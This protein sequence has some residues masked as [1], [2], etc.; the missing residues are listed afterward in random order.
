MTRPYSIDL[1]ERAV[2]LVEAGMTIR[3]AAET[4]NI[5]P[6][7]LPKWRAL[8]QRTGSLSPGKIGGHKKRTLSG[9]LA[10]WL[11]RRMGEAAFTLRG[12]VA[13]LAE[14]GIKTDTRAVWVFAH[15]QNLSFK[16]NRA[17]RRAGSS[18]H[19]P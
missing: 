4:L 13:E 11:K 14:Q 2:A 18:R 17:G 1:R 15:E 10:E 8:Q 12:L 7:C 9:E 6:S 19:R 16:K 3:E 5:S